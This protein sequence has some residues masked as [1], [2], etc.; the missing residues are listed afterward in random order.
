[1]A[2]G[3]DDLAAGPQ[4]VSSLAGEL[5]VAPQL[6]RNR[7]RRRPP[8][9]RRRN[10]VSGAG[11][12]GHRAVP[13]GRAPGRAVRRTTM[14]PVQRIGT[15]SNER[16]QAEAALTGLD[17][18]SKRLDPRVRR[19]KRRTRKTRSA[20]RTG[21]RSPLSLSPSASQRLAAEIADLRVQ[22]ESKRN[23]ETQSGVA[24]T[25]RAEAASLNGRRNSLEA[26]IREHSYSTDTVRDLFR[27]DS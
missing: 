12:R 24:A 25:T 21:K 26:L 7:H 15:A 10:S 18:K 3:K 19:R 11:A 13:A 6:P 2:A 1:M 16:A 27:A 22:I 17:G 5:G 8:L 23:E 14:Q 4:P 20:A 9:A